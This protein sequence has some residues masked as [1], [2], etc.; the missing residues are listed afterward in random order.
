D[1][2]GTDVMLANRIAMGPGL[3]PPRFRWVSYAD[4]LMLPLSNAAEAAATPDRA[5]LYPLEDRLL[6]RYLD[7]LHVAKLPPTL[8]TYAHDVVTATLERQRREGCVAV[9]FEAAYLRALDFDDA[10]RDAAAR[11]YARYAGGGQPPHADYKTLQ[12]YLFRYIARE[13]GRLG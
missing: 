12:D 7:D 6:R 4:A 10:P 11:I 9:K 8:D 1:R 5:K 13:A 2:I 3:A